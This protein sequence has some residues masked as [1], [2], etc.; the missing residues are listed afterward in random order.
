ML[1]YDMDKLLID[2][3]NNLMGRFIKTFEN[4]NDAIAAKALKYGVEAMIATGDK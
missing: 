1:E 3:E 2:N 4:T